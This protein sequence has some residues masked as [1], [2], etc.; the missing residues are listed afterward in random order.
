MVFMFVIIVII[1]I[2]FLIITANSGKYIENQKSV[3][4]HKI[5]LA[6][7]KVDQM[8]LIENQLGKAIVVR[9]SSNLHNSFSVHEE[10]KVVL[11]NKKPIHYS[12][13]R[14]C[15]LLVDGQTSTS[16]TSTITKSSTGNVIGRAVVG[17]VIAGG[18]GAIIGGVSGK[19]TGIGHTTTD[20]V[21][22]YSV[23]IST[24]NIAESTKIYRC[25]D[26][27][28]FATNLVDTLNIIIERP[29]KN[30]TPSKIVNLDG[31]SLSIEENSVVDL[32]ILS[33]K[34]SK[35]QEINKSGEFSN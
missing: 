29:D 24:N 30:E 22:C 5:R 32:K 12:N 7:A 31:F 1:F 14:A 10:S 33:E 15:E 23:R 18:A 25:N 17:T 8:E 21:T 3:E 9:N 11:I 20:I 6:Q 16:T 4:F 27:I 13:I 26:D 34:L 2:V 19:K 35:L 28:E